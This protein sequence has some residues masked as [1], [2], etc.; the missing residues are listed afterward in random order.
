MDK[1]L[2]KQATKI[3]AVMVDIQKKKKERDKYS[4]SI[5]IHNT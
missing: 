4:R 2:K 1:L 3:K 5:I